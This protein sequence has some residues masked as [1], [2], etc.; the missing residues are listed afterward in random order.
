MPKRPDAARVRAAVAAGDPPLSASFPDD[1]DWHDEQDRWLAEWS[2]RVLPHGPRRRRQRDKCKRE[3]A[4]LVAEAAK[5]RALPPASKRK[6]A[7]KPPAPTAHEPVL[8]GPPQRKRPLPLSQPAYE[9]AMGRYAIANEAR[10]KLPRRSKADDA[11]R[12]Q[13]ERE[14]TA[15]AA[16]EGDAEADERM[17]RERERSQRRRD[18]ELAA[19]EAARESDAARERREEQEALLRAIDNALPRSDSLRMAWDAAGKWDEPLCLAIKAWAAHEPPDGSQA[20]EN[21]VM[22]VAVPAATLRVNGSLPAD[23]YRRVGALHTLRWLMPKLS[24]AATPGA[25][26]PDPRIPVADR[27]ERGYCVCGCRLPPSHRPSEADL[28]LGG[29]PAEDQHDR[30]NGAVPF[31]RLHGVRRGPTPYPMRLHQSPKVALAV[32]V[33]FSDGCA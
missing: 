21:A 26:D 27:A 14:A 3:H 7:R 9:L 19:A 18:A 12:K 17:R 5:G 31:C 24:F 11:S 22:A 25:L 6:R 1:D 33:V 2:A 16:A 13:G 29:P 15:R 8:A 32:P 4:R 10:R 20:W 23:G 30:G 28:K